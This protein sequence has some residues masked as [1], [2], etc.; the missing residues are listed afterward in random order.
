MVQAKIRHTY[1]RFVGAVARGRGM[2]SEEVDRIGR[3]HVY[4]G[5]QAKPINLVTHF[6]GLNAAL[7]EAKRRMNL[8]PTTTIDI[9]ELPVPERNPLGPAA[10]LFG[11]TALSLDTLLPRD[12]IQTRM[13]FDLEWR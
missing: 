10:A 11:A 2:K 4:T 8:A 3:G 6:G 12:Q 9:T 5:D 13:P 1:D 7:D